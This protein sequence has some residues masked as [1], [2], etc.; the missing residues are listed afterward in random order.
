MGTFKLLIFKDL[1]T[2]EIIEKNGKELKKG[3]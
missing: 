1:H 2:L 3:V